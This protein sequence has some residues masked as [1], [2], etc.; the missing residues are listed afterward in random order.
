MNTM[1][2]G[3]KR[4]RGALLFSALAVA[5]GCGEE[6]LLSPGASDTETYEE[7]ETRA[8]DL[9]GVARVSADTQNGLIAL[10][11]QVSTSARLEIRKIVRSSTLAE[12]QRLAEA[13]L[14]DATVVSG[15]LIIHPSHPDLRSHENVRVDYTLFC[16]S[17]AD[18]DLRTVNGTISV[19]GMNGALLASVANGGIDVVCPGGGMGPIDAGGLNGRVTV[20]L[21]A[22]HP[23]DVTATTLDGCVR[24]NYG[25]GLIDRCKVGLQ[26]IRMGEPGGIP[27]ELHLVNGLIEIRQG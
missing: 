11:G 4:I 24:G 19:E 15:Q 5:S 17:S 16:P 13:V 23:F 18:L 21:P 14:V 2:A 6:A 8:L 9:A 25:G 27:C 12:A 22:D 10:R 20:A 26:Q 7:T 3:I 1:R